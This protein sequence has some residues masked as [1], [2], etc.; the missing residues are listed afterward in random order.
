MHRT[1]EITAAPQ[2]TDALLGELARLDHVIGLSVQR[3]ASIK[4]PGDAIMVHVLNR[5]ADQVM[6]IA[7]QAVV[8]GGSVALA[9]GTALVDLASQH[10]I[11]HDVD[12]ATWEEAETG[13][14]HQG[15][16]TVNFLALMAFGGVVATVGLLS[17]PVPMAIALIASSVIA[18]G[19]E[20]IAK[21][22]LGL[23]LR[24][25]PVV[26]RGAVSALAGYA[27]LIAASA[28]TFLLL[29]ALGDATASG[30]TGSKEVQH[31]AHPLPKDVVLSLAS[32]T[33]GLVMITAYRRTVIAGPLIGMALISAA[34]LIGAALAAGE[35]QLGGDAAQR[36]ALE[37]AL[38]VGAGAVVVAI[39]KATI[40]RRDPLV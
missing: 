35:G 23:V 5:G 15:A 6:D 17:D 40:H 34:A 7:G 3:D 18:P 32:A 14:R 20:P 16:I 39:K 28:G 38:L 36:L 8:R 33:A 19:F 29:V 27:A 4:P 37:T 12:E 9:E 30:L 31:L 11:D 26:V 1:I 2:L 10:R 25:W 13:L 22:S 24:R 21:I